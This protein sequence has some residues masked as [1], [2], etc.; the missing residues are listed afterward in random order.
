MSFLLDDDEAQGS[1][2]LKELANDIRKVGTYAQE[3]LNAGKSRQE[4]LE[5]VVNIHGDKY[6]ALFARKIGAMA[7]N[8]TKAK[9]QE[10]Q[11]FLLGALGLSIIALMYLTYMYLPIFSNKMG[12]LTVVGITLFSLSSIMFN[13]YQFRGDALYNAMF[14]MAIA[15]LALG[16]TILM[17]QYT[18]LTFV[19]IGIFGLTFVLAFILRQRAFPALRYG[20]PRK[21]R[22]GKYIMD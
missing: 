2:R 8:A 20:G 17:Q 9:Y 16:R 18:I 15:V 3:A 11:Y 10:L 5:T 7:S 4:I 22:D 13:I 1:Q 12:I 21:G 6:E 14:F 19:F